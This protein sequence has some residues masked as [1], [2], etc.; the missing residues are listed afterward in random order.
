MRGSLFFMQ[1]NKPHSAPHRRYPTTHAVP[2]R[3]NHFLLICD[4]EILGV[5]FSRASHK[6]KTLTMNLRLVSW[7]A[8]VCLTMV[9]TARPSDDAFSNNL[10][11]CLI[12]SL[13]IRSSYSNAAK[14]THSCRPSTQATQIRSW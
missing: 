6:A 5:T 9:E 14:T 11:D 1:T 13:K 8:G 12:K 4:R 2:D 3:L 10:W 7:L